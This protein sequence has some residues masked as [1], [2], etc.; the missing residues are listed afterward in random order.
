MKSLILSLTIIL[1]SLQVF[2][3]E[4]SFNQLGIK[5]GKQEVPEG[6]EEGVQAPDFTA[7]SQSGETI[8][9]SEI[10]KNQPVVLFFY[11]GY[12]CPVCSKYLK[13]YADSLSLLKQQGVKILAITP[14]TAG[15][16]EKTR[17]NT[18]V[19]ITIISDKTEEIM[20]A[21][22]VT[23]H[24]TEKYQDKIRNAFNAD[25]AGTNDQEKAR[26]PVPAT[27]IIDQNQK[28]AARQFDPDYTNRASVKWMLE[29]LP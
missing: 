15:N 19:D 18:G 24:V 2:A 9:L 11:R 7:K 13:R 16:V 10:V 22:K 23:F 3:Q 25:I 4:S 14:E 5:T 1:T 27:Y 6:L 8:D 26:L 12:W 20:N 17:K 29:N 28:I 21:Y